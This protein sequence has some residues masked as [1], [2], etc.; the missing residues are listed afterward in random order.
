M[1][2]VKAYAVLAIVVIIAS[3][4]VGFVTASYYSVGV[5]E[6]AIVVNPYDGTITLG[7]AGP[8]A[9]A[10]KNP[11]AHVVTIST[12]IHTIAL[13]GENTISGLTIDNLNVNFDVVV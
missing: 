5:S 7:A 8:T 11:L 9:W 4:I 13:D 2:N 10:S 3:T 12:A 6:Q 1:E